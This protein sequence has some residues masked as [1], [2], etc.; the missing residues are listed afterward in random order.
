[1]G[2]FN[3]RLGISDG[4]GGSTYWVEAQVDTGA[5]HTLI[6]AAIL[7]SLGIQPK[8]KKSASFA[9]GRIGT[10]YVGSA[11]FRIGDRE[12]SSPIVFGDSDKCL[13]GATTLQMLDLIPDTTNERLIP[14]PEITL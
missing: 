5:T 1:M 9:D 12:G 2:T 7:T 11:W 13:L 10:V 14:T 8:A 4:S 3:A 6:P